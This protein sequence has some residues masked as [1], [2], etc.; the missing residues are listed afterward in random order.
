MSNIVAASSAD[1]IADP[2]RLLAELRAGNVVYLSDLGRTLALAEVDEE[3]ADMVS[4]R[5]NRTGIENTI[6]VFTKGYAQHAP[7][8]KIA[9]DPPHALNATA[10]SASMAIHDYSVR[11]EYI[12]PRIAE[13]ARQFIERNRAALLDYWEC[14]I[15][16]A[17][18]I[19]R[20]KR[21]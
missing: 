17:E 15:D 3:A 14:E 21:V 10:K 7:R 19:E 5:F 20:L 6:F 11:G 12:P 16:T 18:L 13:Q 1:L 2:A 4:L 8:I 9:I